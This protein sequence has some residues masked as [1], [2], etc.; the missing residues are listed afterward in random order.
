M[1]H[2]MYHRHDATTQCLHTYM[3]IVHSATIKG[4]GMPVL[5]V[6]VS[7]PLSLSGERLREME[8]VPPTVSGLGPL[9][10]LEQALRE[11][12]LDSRK[13]RE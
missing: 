9:P 8:V 12:Q 5:T 6:I 3:T 1:S 7:S 2:G 4:R 11:E 13:G 10:P